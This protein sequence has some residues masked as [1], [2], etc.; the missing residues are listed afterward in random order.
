MS[1]VRILQLKLLNLHSSRYSLSVLFSYKV[2]LRLFAREVA[3]VT[4]HAQETVHG[5]LQSENTGELFF[6]S[7]VCS[8]LTLSMLVFI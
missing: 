8:R 5:L 6:C 2:V 1:W 4:R 7:F 3:A